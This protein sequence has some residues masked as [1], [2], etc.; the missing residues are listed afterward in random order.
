[1]DLF[2]RVTRARVGV[3]ELLAVAIV[4]AVGVNLVASGIWN[5]LGPVTSVIV[6]AIGIVAII[7]IVVIVRF[8]RLGE[9]VEVEGFIAVHANEVVHVDE[10]QLAEHTHRAL[11]AAL[12]ENK[13]L[14]KQW[15]EDPIVF[16]FDDD[17]PGRDHHN[18]DGGGAR[19]LREA[20]EFV[21]LE[22]LSTHL[23]DYFG[24]DHALAR[25][26]REHSRDDLLK[27][28]P[29][30]RIL[31]LLTSPLEDRI[32]LIEAEQAE[33]RHFMKIM[34]IVETPEGREEKLYMA[35]DGHYM[36]TRFELVL[37]SDVSVERV[38]P[39][40]ICLRGKFMDT[41]LVARFDGYAHTLDREFISGYLRLPPKEFY[42]HGE[43]LGS[44]YNVSFEFNSRLKWRS[45]FSRRGWRLHRWTE[46]FAQ[47]VGDAF[48]ADEFFST[49]QWPA[50]RTLV[51][52][53][54][55][56]ERERAN[57]VAVQ[58][59]GDAGTARPGQE[60]TGPKPGAHEA[61]PTSVS[62]GPHLT[63]LEGPTDK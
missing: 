10:Y 13:A 11:N 14:A 37:P 23:T 33:G 21:F 58:T 12:R 26:T 54:R 44:A 7:A 41:E 34:R 25:H 61:D 15:E 20:L 16:P 8:R 22:M 53:R 30:N 38:E 28:L 27:L 5:W 1:M 6:G 35:G 24:A 17:E 56:D 40:R 52:I 55:A 63:V 39:G 29:Q 50:V 48:G 36:Y 19:I 42:G 62:P 4:L 43:R 57:K 60:E 31:D 18:F 3:S 9:N 49:I 45:F 2:R 47:S 32:A 46:A 59:S 51:R